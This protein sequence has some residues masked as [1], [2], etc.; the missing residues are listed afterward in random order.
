MNIGNSLITDHSG[1]DIEYL[2]GSNE[3]KATVAP[4]DLGT[5]K[6]LDKIEI[7]EK[8]YGSSKP[9][10]IIIRGRIALDQLNESSR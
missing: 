6:T 7:D 10:R 5:A 8:K 1:I 3:T 9:R 2:K 4:S